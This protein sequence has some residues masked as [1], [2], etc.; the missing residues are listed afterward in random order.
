M[1]D[2][3]KNLSGRERWLMGIMI[4]LLLIMA[5]VFLAVRPVLQSKIK[6]E[7]A[8]TSAQSDLQ[9]VKQN[10][11][12]LSGGATSTT[13]T[14]PIDRNGIYR[15]AQSNGLQMNKF[16]PERDG[17]MKVTFDDVSSQ[18]VFK[19]VVDTTA[20]YA[21]T[22]SAAQITRKDEGKVNVTITFRPL[23]S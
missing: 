7:R 10:L 16:Q 4:S 22:V 8:Q 3:W 17:A 23:G 15:M 12:L 13:G 18:Q 5:V 1:M 9:L 11:S 6:A 2:Y 14:Q 20:T 21:T 19:F